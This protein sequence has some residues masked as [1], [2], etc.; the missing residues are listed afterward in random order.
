MGRAKFESLSLLFW[1]F[2]KYNQSLYCALL[3]NNRASVT[4]LGHNGLL[5]DFTSLKTYTYWYISRQ[6]EC[7]IC[8]NTTQI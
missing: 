8:Q 4:L 5:L 1:I 2:L 6:I 7:Y 3:N